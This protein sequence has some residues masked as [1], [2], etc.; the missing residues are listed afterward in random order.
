MD[1][2]TPARFEAPVF[3]TE[4]FTN[5]EEL[6]E[7][8]LERI[9][10]AFS[11]SGKLDDLDDDQVRSPD[12]KKVRPRDPLVGYLEIVR[13][14][15]RFFEKY[16]WRPDPP[17]YLIDIIAWKKFDGWNV[18]F[19]NPSG[20]VIRDGIF[21]DFISDDALLIAMDGK[22]LNGTLTFAVNENIVSEMRIVNEVRLVDIA[23]R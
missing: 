5:L 3:K 4:K 17:H 10:E 15:R 18:V 22:N 23:A 13:I 7:A 12:T 16:I 2:K 14:M 11:K 21:C 19:K 9:F 8:E 6:S 1:R 20:E